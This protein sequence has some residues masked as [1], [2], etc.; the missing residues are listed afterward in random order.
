MRTVHVIDRWRWIGCLE[1]V[2]LPVTELRVARDPL[3]LDQYRILAAALRKAR[4]GDLVDL[5]A[6]Q[7][8]AASG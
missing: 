5:S 2:D 1:D 4:P 8:C 7:P 3:D 6:A